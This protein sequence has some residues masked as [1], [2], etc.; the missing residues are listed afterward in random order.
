MKKRIVV[1]DDNETILNQIVNY[2]SKNENIEVVGTAKDGVEELKIVRELSPDIV[3]TDVEMPNMT[4]VEVIEQMKN[5][6]YKPEFI[7]MT[8]G[9]SRDT[10]N[11]LNNLDIRKLFH[12]PMDYSELLEEL[13][14]EDRWKIEDY[15][16]FKKIRIILADDEKW[17]TDEVEKELKKF[18]ELDIIG[19]AHSNEE[20]IS[21]IESLSPDI[22]ITDIMRN[23][24]IGGLDIIKEYSQKEKSPMFLVLSTGFDCTPLMDYNNVASYVEKFPKINYGILR[25]N[26]RNIHYELLKKDQ[27][28]K[29]EI[30]KQ[31]HI[32]EQE[33]KKTSI[34]DKIKKWFK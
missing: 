30:Y 8:G 15:D 20:E 28:R 33:N 7:V 1:A 6:I 10:M 18:E 19:I 32:K 12:K 27:A 17:F 14:A 5:Y 29:Y 21:L 22:V 2:I 34:L 23:G 4:G 24:K 9:M 31:N 11:R 16:Y 13:L 25:A 26:L 3:I